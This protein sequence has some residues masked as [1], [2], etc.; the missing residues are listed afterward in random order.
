MGRLRLHR[1]EMQSPD[2]FVSGSAEL[3]AE[4]GPGTNTVEAEFRDFYLSPVWKLLRPPFD[5]ASR[6]TGRASLSGKA[7]S[8]R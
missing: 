4:S 7:H 3:F 5:L 8:I 2:G 6:A 1:V